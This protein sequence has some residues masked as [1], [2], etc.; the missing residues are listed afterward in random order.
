MALVLV[1]A[2]HSGCPDFLL[3]NRSFLEGCPFSLN[4]PPLLTDI[5]YGWPATV[6]CTGHKTDMLSGKD[7][8]KEIEWIYFENWKHIIH[9]KSGK[10]GRVPGA[11]DV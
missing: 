10:T 8:P 2:I 9:K 5:L 11:C 6:I 3:E 1:G 7:L 4:P